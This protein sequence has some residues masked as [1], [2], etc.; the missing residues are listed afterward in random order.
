[1]LYNLLSSDKP[2]FLVAHALTEGHAPYLSSRI[3]DEDFLNEYSR[4]HQ[5]HQELD[6]QMEYYMNYLNRGTKRIFMSDHG[7]P[8]V[9]EEFHT[10]F[11][12]SGS[13]LLVKW[14][15]PKTSGRKAGVQVVL[16][17]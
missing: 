9:R 2:V 8:L 17:K 15:L 10:Y 5:A 14:V 7:Q 16:I 6:E 3:E 1:M 11:V 13:E 4:I 12:V